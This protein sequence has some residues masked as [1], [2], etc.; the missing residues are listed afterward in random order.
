MA[1]EGLSM[2]SGQGGLMRYNE[3][4]PSKFKFGP[5]MVI[6]MIVAVVMAMAIIKII[7]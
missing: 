6:I 7:F 4:F 5:V 3:E 2:P 1:G